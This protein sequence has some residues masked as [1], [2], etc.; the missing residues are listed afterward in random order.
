LHRGD[1][2][3]RKSFVSTYRYPE[4]DGNGNTA[5]LAGPEQVFRVVLRRPVQNFGVVIVSRAPG[6]KVQPRVVARD[7]ENRLTG[8][9]ALPFVLN[10]Y[11]AGYMD[12]VLAAGAVRPPAGTYDVVFDSRTKAGAGSFTFRFWL[13]DVTPPSARLVST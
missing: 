13:D 11:L 10:P 12:M 8:Y 6:V 5:V 1:T 4:L 3:G 9:A 2:R 7:D